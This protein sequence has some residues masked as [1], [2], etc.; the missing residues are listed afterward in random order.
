MTLFDDFDFIVKFVLGNLPDL[1]QSAAAVRAGIQFMWYDFGNFFLG[2]GVH[3]M[4]GMSRLPAFCP[5]A[6][7]S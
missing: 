6:F 2:K 1:G 7:F 5:A 3:G 4:L